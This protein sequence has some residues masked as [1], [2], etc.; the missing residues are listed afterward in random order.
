MRSFDLDSEL[1]HD[2]DHCNSLALN[3][4]VGRACPPN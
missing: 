1:N 2:R 3:E 4:Q